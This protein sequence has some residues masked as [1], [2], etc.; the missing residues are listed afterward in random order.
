[1]ALNVVMPALEMAQETG[2]ILAWLKK[3]GEP[4]AKGEPLLEIETDKA[5]VE[6][7]APGDGILAGVRA[8]VGAVVPVGETIAWLVQPGE[9]PPAEAAKN[10]SGRS[11]VSRYECASGRGAGCRPVARGAKISPKARR[12][13]GEKGVDPGRVRG[14]GPGGEVLAADILAAAEA[15]PAGAP[16]TAAGTGKHLSAVARLMAERT[17]QSW[18]TAPHFFVTREVDARGLVELHRELRANGDSAGNGPKAT[19]TDLLILLVARTLRKHPRLNSSWTDQGIELHAEVNVSV[20]MAVDEGVVAAVIHKAD[21][22]GLGEISVARA[23]LAE[24]AQ[25]GR[26]RPSDIAG[27]TF[28]ISNLGMYGVDS[29]TAIIVPP[30]SAI[31][32]VGRIADRV[33]AEEGR[34][35]VRPMLSLTLSC[36]HR[37][38]DGAGAA[39]FMNGLAEAIEAPRKWMT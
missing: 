26:L 22:M 18:T 27:G 2:K 25:S 20:A 5:V 24:R 10:Q 14:S 4:V 15:S 36:D 13:A 8:G 35:A 7:E 3:E 21:T 34:A 32:A 28:T 29:F 19:I 9:T 16:A 11:A 37:A 12:L 39:Q 33:V 31:L 17:T 30:Q 23:E 6:I 1:M 38:V